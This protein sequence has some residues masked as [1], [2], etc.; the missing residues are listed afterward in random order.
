MFLAGAAQGAAPAAGCKAP[1]G[2]LPDGINRDCITTGILYN[3]VVPLSG[4]DAFD[5]NIES[6]AVDLRSW[7]QIYF[8]L[9][10]AAL[11]EPAWPRA[12]KMRELA[13]RKAAGGVIPIGLIDVE[14][15]RIARKARAAASHVPLKDA[16][17]M[18][19]P[20]RVLRKRAFT[21]S[22]LRS[23]TYR[24]ASVHFHLDP[25]FYFTN[26]PGGPCTFRID[27]DDGVG[28]REVEMGAQCMISY[29]QPGRKTI[30]VSAEFDDGTNLHAGFG[31]DV[32][33]L[34]VP[35][36]DD[37]LFITASIPYLGEYASGQAYIYYGES[38]TSL[39]NP[40]LVIEGF[41]IDNTMNW[42]ELYT[43]MNQ[44]GMIE[45]LH[46]EGFDAVVLNFTEAVDYIQRNS[47]LVVELIQQVNGLIPPE[48]DLAIV[49]AS[50]GGLCGRFALAYMEDQG[51]DHNTRTFISFD[52]PQKGANIPLG[53]QY[54]MLFFAE[55]SADAAFLLERLG[56][57]GSR[58]ML[59]YF[60]SDPP[61]ATG[62]SDP[63]FGE[64]QADLDSLG[65]YP[66]APRKVAVANGSGHMLD[67]G[68]S[69][70]EQ[71]IL[72]EYSS[73][74][75]DIIGNVWAVPDNTYHIIF[76]GL[77]D[78]IWP[79]P[80]KDL[81]V[82]VDGTKPY[83][84]A[85]GGTRSSM[86]QMDSSE[87]PYGDIIALHD[88]HCF[89]PTISA[90]DLDTDNLFYDID[91]DP[92][93]LA[94]TPFDTVY[95]PVANEEHIAITAESRDWFLD[96]ISRGVLTDVPKRGMPISGVRLEPCR[97][98]P[99]HSAA[100]I[101]FYVP[102]AQHIDLAIY[103]IRGRRVTRLLDRTVSPG[104]GSASWN[105]EDRRGRQVSSGLYFCTLEAGDATRV[106]RLIKLR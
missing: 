47:F 59:V 76:D 88:S 93:I 38:N 9:Y 96:E 2:V 50:M 42:E 1:A 14:Y 84:S 83:D 92:D 77:M 17:P 94:H 18:K 79:L 8:E 28:P 61:T 105:G 36:P 98:N 10:Q 75:V 60:Y 68:F 6:P 20:D 71:I 74:L 7:R 78:L 31:F 56:T 82:Y 70:G 69:P 46:A 22:A 65:G 100:T 103:D 19:G 48:A 25:D 102:S 85:P 49:G 32:R 24:G 66:A 104:W 33:Q 62:E 73:L 23:H 80:D 54:W 64:L 13:G 99:F 72:Y 52:A 95:Y 27:F 15:N 55:D 40:V 29:S 97:P 30:R 53:V 5:G 43:D 44:E 86:A 35:S 45:S 101:R 91:G 87:A 3:R 57:P 90:L 58:Q 41:D 4:I 106:R 67:Q 39:V 26:M 12:S 89:I 16:V 11:D 21:A 63:L 34:Q 37:T 51:L 81:T